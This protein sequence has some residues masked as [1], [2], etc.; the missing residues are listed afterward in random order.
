MSCRASPNLR[1]AFKASFVGRFAARSPRAA[2]FEA[3][4]RG[5]D[6]IVGFATCRSSA[7]GGGTGN[8]CSGAV[9]SLADS[10]GTVAACRLA[11][12]GCSGAFSAA[13]DATST[14]T[15]LAVPRSAIHGK[16]RRD[17]QFRSKCSQVCRLQ[18]IAG[19]SGISAPATRGRSRADIGLS[20]P[21]RSY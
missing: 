1:T 18:G 9:I 7:V 15:A 5:C 6:S 14:V 4:R 17:K 16:S 2:F 11:I 3:G 12:K 13:A 8:P 19:G 20:P 10:W 21:S